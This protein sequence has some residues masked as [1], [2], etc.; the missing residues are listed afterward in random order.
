[1]VGASS[2]LEK[3]GNKIFQ[4]LLNWEY[5]VVPVNPNEEEI[6]WIKAYSS[7]SEISFNID[8]VICVVPPVVTEKII[9]EIILLWIKNV[10]MQPWSESDVAIQKC[11][12]NWINVVH[13]SCI[14]I[15]RKTNM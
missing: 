13:N 12:H 7:L 3:Y 14:M 6:L 10:W 8:V 11:L 9:D 4:D 15:Q 1:L 5:N 2:N